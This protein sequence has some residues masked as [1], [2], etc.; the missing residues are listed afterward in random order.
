MPHPRSQRQPRI[1]VLLR[2][3]ELARPLGPLD[4]ASLAG[5]DSFGCA[6]SCAFPEARH[7]QRTGIVNKKPGCSQKRRAHHAVMTKIIARLIKTLKRS[8]R[9]N[10]YTER[11]AD[12]LPDFAHGSMGWPG[13]QRVTARRKIIVEC[14]CFRVG[15]MAEVITRHVG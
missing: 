1:S 10:S 3:L 15:E 5:D 14:A 11:L 7:R 2:Y 12:D 6:R 9:L 8:W 13:D 4:L